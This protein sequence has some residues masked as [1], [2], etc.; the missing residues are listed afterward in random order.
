MATT[1]ESQV[2]DRSELA[3]R[4]VVGLTAFMGGQANVMMQLSL[5]PVGYGVYESKVDSGRIDL[6][7]VKRLRTT[8]T[9]L[10]VAM[11]GNDADRNAYRKEVD[12]AHRY[13]RSDDSSP[14]RYNAFDPELQKWVAACLYVGF[15]DSVTF[16][17]GPPPQRFADRFYNDCRRLGTT[18]QMPGYMWPADR[19]AFGAYWA[20]MLP[21]LAVDDTIR[22]YLIDQV[23]GLG[24][25]P[26]IV[27]IPFSPLSRFFNTG[28]LPPEF[29]DTFDIAWSERD[30]RRFDAIM[31]GIGRVATVTPAWIRLF[32]LNA[33]LWDMRRRVGRGRP[34]V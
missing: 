24:F 29:R 32:P 6:H 20:S 25:L 28:F 18:L 12:R 14:V 16:L 33:L 13:V 34:V 26:R 3:Y 21:T 15:R 30:Q 8:L 5:A 9:Y 23:L 17:Y 31:R 2:S 1:V 4:Y 11:L 19:D 7:P 10:A 22:G 27:R